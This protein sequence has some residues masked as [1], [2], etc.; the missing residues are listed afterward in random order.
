MMRVVVTGAFPLDPSVIPGGVTAVAHYLTKGLARIPEVDLHVIC[1][2]TIVPENR[3]VERDGITVHFLTNRYR[4]S[5]LMNL[6]FQ[7]RKIARLVKRL[8]PDIMHAQGLGLPT[9]AALDSGLP[10]VVTVHGVFWKEPFEHP[11]P[12]TRLGGRLRQRAARKQLDR[13]RNVIVTSGHVTAILPTHI[14]YRKFVINNP[15]SEEIFAIR[16]EP[17]APHILVIGGTRKRKDPLTTVR[18]MERV[19]QRIPEATL[20]LLGPDSN[21]ELDQQVAEFI[22]SRD[23]GDHIKLLGLVPNDV[24]WDE[25]RKASLLLIPSL[26][27]TAPV[28]ISESYAVGLPVVGSDAGGIPYMVRENETGFVRPVGDVTGLA[29]RVVAI[30]EDPDLRDRLSRRARA[31]GRDEFALDAIAAKTF[32]VY[33]SILGG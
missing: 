5:Q 8:S 30:L 19:L 18:V 31:I 33:E 23:L 24:L 7:R 2:E 32:A 27:E 25:Y 13:I 14:D 21:T 1:C 9:F 26:E 3:E 17:C 20:H 15:V 10:N 12:I 22:R 11:S 28:A 16:N 6:F 4:L 29:D